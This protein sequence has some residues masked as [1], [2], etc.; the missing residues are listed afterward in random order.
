[1]GAGPC[2][3]FGVRAIA[4]SQ[5]DRFATG[6]SRYHAACASRYKAAGKLTGKSPY[7]PFNAKKARFG[8]GTAL[9]STSTESALAIEG[10]A[11]GL[12]DQR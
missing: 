3:P 9:R 5:P 2:G 11:K 4:L 6:A 1:M 12:P 8:R 7:V 10:K